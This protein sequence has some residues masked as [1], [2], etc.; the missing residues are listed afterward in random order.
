MVRKKCLVFKIRLS[1]EASHA[2]LLQALVRLGGP[3]QVLRKADGLKSSGPRWIYYG[4][5][6]AYWGGPVEEIIVSRRLV[7][8]DPVAWRQRLQAAG[9]QVAQVRSMPQNGGEASFA[10][11]YAVTV[12]HL[13][14][15][16]TRLLG[17]T[18]QTLPLPGSGPASDSPLGKRLES[19]A[20]RALYALGLDMGEVIISA[21]EEGR[22][23]ID[24]LSISSEI[25]SSAV[26]NGLALAMRDELAEQERLLELS[27]ERLIGMDPEFLLFNDTTRKVI[28]A[29]RYLQFHGEAGC[30]VLRYRGRRLFPLAELRPRPGQ[31]PREVVTHLL[32]AFRQAQA[33]IDNR[34]LIW[35]AGAMPQQGFPLGGHLH[36]SGVLLTA[37]L[38]RTLDN[39]L[40]LPL[41]LLE[42]EGSARRRPKYGFLGDFRRKEY[43]G[44]E[45]RTLPSFLVSPRITKG[46]VALACLIAENASQ[47]LARPLDREE[48]FSAFYS[49]DRRMLQAALPRIIADIQ[50]A[51]S[52]A[53]YESYLV[54]FFKLLLSGRTWDESADIR[55][56]WK[57]TGPSLADG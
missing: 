4:P 54:P 40:A 6:E 35:Q 51:S 47:L 14:V 38:L 27:G 13:R 55:R 9:L 12:F 25:R 43:G 17:N 2:R 56:A 21:G 24:P 44:F 3:Y 31:E 15:L 7:L 33:A 19:T 42:A 20:I 5:E 18:G 8:R 52:Y 26:A 50:A 36:F 34:E 48:I 46:V 57:L 49:G 28:P 37:E 39:Y 41:S 11:R 29:S 22:F 16:E 30:D 53:A 10:R 32:R 45:Y 23:T 1:S